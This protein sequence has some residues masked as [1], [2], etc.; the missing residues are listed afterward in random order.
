MQIDIHAQNLEL[1]ATLRAF[2]EEKIGDVERV[3]GDAGPA[4]AKVEVG[5]PSNHH[6]SGP[7]YYAEINLTVGGQLLR[8][9]AKNY[10]LHS[11]IVD[12]KDDLKVQI[13][14]FK[15]KLLEKDRQPLP[16]E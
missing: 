10:D 7:I 3:V 11:A 5:I 16:E 15:E 1:N 13:K 8:A 2:I 9:E 14:K 12:A 4:H 6:Q